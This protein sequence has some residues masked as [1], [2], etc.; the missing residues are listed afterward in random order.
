MNKNQ[1]E[2]FCFVFYIYRIIL[3]AGMNIMVANGQ[4]SLLMISWH[5]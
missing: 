4:P 2:S 3:M 5:G 1:E